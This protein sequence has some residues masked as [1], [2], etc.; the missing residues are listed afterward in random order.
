[1]CVLSE[2]PD[3][4][5]QPMGSISSAQPGPS[6]P[7]RSPGL[8]YLEWRF[9]QLNLCKK[10]N[11]TQ[12]IDLVNDD[13]VETL[14]NPQNLSLLASLTGL[15]CDHFSLYNQVFIVFSFKFTKIVL[16]VLIKIHRSLQ[17]AL[18]SLLMCCAFFVVIG[19]LDTTTMF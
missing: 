19:R 11:A 14:G 16:L 7:I 5:G 17:K 13:E 3:N 15:I 6:R 9:N 10:S 18:R 8:H 4:I 12:M 2:A 1:M